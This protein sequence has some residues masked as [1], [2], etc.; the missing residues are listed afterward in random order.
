MKLAQEKLCAASCDLWRVSWLQTGTLRGT[1][2]WGTPGHPRGWGQKEESTKEP[3]ELGVFV[4]HMFG[5]VPRNRVWVFTS[6]DPNRKYSGSFCR[7]VVKASVQNRSHSAFEWGR[8]G[9]RSLA[10]SVPQLKVVSSQQAPCLLCSVGRT[11][12]PGASCMQESL[13][14]LVSPSLPSHAH[15]AVL[16]AFSLGMCISH[17]SRVC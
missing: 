17:L 1:G 2:R 7:Q 12:A 4:M 16:A 5:G 15:L 3:D 11:T 13:P 6:S 14:R 9:K 10:K 8:G